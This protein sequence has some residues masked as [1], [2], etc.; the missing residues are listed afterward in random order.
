M[1]VLLLIALLVAFASLPFVI[2]AAY[3]WLAWVTEKGKMKK[4][5]DNVVKALDTQNATVVSITGGEVVEGE[6][7]PVVRPDGSAAMAIVVNTKEG[8][9]PIVWVVE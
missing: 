5:V 2:V 8:E 1:V 6:T 7:V 4:P 9:P 3:A